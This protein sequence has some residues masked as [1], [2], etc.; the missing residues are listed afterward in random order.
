MSK[1]RTQR[2]LLWAGLSLGKQY[3]IH[4]IKHMRTSSH[5][6][7]ST[8]STFVTAVLLASLIL[9]ARPCAGLS[10]RLPTNVA[11]L[12]LPTF[13]FFASSLAKDPDQLQG[14]AGA[15]KV[16][17]SD[18]FYLAEILAKGK[19]TRPPSSL[20]IVRELGP[21]SSASSPPLAMIGSPNLDA[22]AFVSPE[23]SSRP[24][25]CPHAPIKKNNSV[26]RRPSE[27]NEGG[28]NYQASVVR[29]LAF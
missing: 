4:T 26:R 28:V 9:E 14:G 10:L 6:K 1:A 27:E 13:H 7:T 5:T 25:C 19:F 23:P 2:H 16:S 29:K 12:G 21:Y 20:S 8:T 24:A 15:Y 11:S 3:F 17:S 22:S 18:Q